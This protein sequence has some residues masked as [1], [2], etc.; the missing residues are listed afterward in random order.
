MG[1]GR[2]FRRRSRGFQAFVLV[3]LAVFLA[4]RGI[5]FPAAILLV[6]AASKA[7]RWWR[8][9]MRQVRG[10]IQRDARENGVHIPDDEVVLDGLFRL[11][12]KYARTS[13]TFAQLSGQYAEIIGSMWLALKMT[14]DLREWRRIVGGVGQEWPTPYGD[15]ESPLKASLSKGKVAARKWQEAHDEAHQWS[16]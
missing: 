8:D 7:L 2:S 10:A 4:E 6:I 13:R 3:C 9:P 12:A 1:C 16:T 5:E 14:H 15:G 11:Y